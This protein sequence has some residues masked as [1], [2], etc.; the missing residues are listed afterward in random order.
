MSGARCRPAGALAVV[1]LALATA[2]CVRGCT[3][4]RP[5]IHLNPN[6]D[7]QPR[8]EAQES[9]EF[10]YDGM[11]MRRP[12]PGTVARGRLVED[13]R[14]TS[15]RA[16]DGSFLGASPVAAEGDLLAR[17]ARQFTIY[18]QPCHDKRG[19]GS[20]ILHQ[21][22]GVPTTSLHLERVVALPDG[23]LFDVI[24]S[25]KGLMPGYAWPLAPHDRWAV[26]AWVRELQGRERGVDVAAAP[27]AAAA[28][29]T[30]GA[31]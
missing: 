5:P 24:T 29:A 19:T 18:C 6:M 25:G 17:G 11:A 10:F 4:S 31:P 21:R 16:A 26:V 2:G 22:G 30:E 1:A 23:E 7:W 14:L 27:D 20:G 3:S 15:G 9:S 13:P 12:V 28:P 8:A